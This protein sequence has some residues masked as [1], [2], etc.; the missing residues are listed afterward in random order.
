MLSHRDFRSRLSRL[1]VA[2]ILGLLIAGSPLPVRAAHFTDVTVPATGPFLADGVTYGLGSRDLD[3]DGDLDTY[4][5][6]H[7]ERPI[8]YRNN[9]DGTMTYPHFPPLFLLPEDHHGGLLADLDQDG[10]IDVYITGGADAGSSEVPKRMFRNDG[11]LLFRDVAADWGL[12]DA[13]ARGRAA[14]AMDVEAD[15]DVD[16][17]VAK[18]VRAISPNSLFLNDGD[19]NFTDVAASAGV[20]DGFGSVGALWADYDRDGD[21]DLFISGEEEVSFETRLY[22]NDGN[23]TFSNVTAAAFP[24]VGQLAAAAWGDYDNDGD[25]DLAAGEGDRGLIDGV[26]WNADSIRFFF[27]TRNGDNGLDGIAFTQTG[28]SA[29]FQLFLNGFAQPSE[30]HI[31]GDDEQPFSAT[32]WWDFDQM[33][34]IPPFTPGGTT[35]FY[36]WSNDFTD[37]WDLRCSA[38]PMA[39]TSFA[40]TITVAPGESFTAVSPV[41]IEPPVEPIV[42]GSQLW[43][44]DGGVFTDVTA[45]AGLSDEANVHHV[46][47]VDLDQDGYLD[48]HVV[49]KGDTANLNEPDLFYRNLGNGTFADETTAWGLEGPT[50]GLGDGAAFEDYDEDGDLDVMKTSGTGPRYLAEKTIVRLYRN[51]APTGN[52]LRVKLVGDTS[53][54]EGYGAWVS[55]TSPGIGTQHRYVAGNNWRGTQEMIDSYFG[56]GT[57]TQ[58][59]E[60]RVEWPSGVVDV[61]TNVAAGEVTILES[62]PATDV[63]ALGEVG[64]GPLRLSARPNPSRGTVLVTARHARAAPGQF[65]VFDAQGRR[66]WRQPLAPGVDR[67]EWDGR[68]GGG[69]ETAA[70]V[71]FVRWTQGDTT[72]REKIVRLPAR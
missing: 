22:R 8:V 16:I 33:F 62:D 69:R 11:N 67:V 40:G 70:G 3:N 44:N 50:E 6:R 66:V 27:N 36:L 4:V 41:G 19:Q 68:D 23:V 42:R 46:T 7:Y 65:E 71:Y 47:W 1:V 32:F 9:G 5:C 35:G 38:P 26:M 48:L 25:L 20:E 43:R 55:C 24:G 28:T 2:A 21:P 18:A 52:H 60:V 53:T 54:R 17:F 72:A 57:D 31:G 12:E 63:P 34:G 10:D 61:L 15:G 37:I 58:A 45:S 30:I 14:S 56:L 64:I 51:D 49:N 13:S 39:G 29:Q 59:T